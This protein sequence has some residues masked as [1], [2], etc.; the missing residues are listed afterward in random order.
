MASVPKKVSDTVLWDKHLAM[1]KDHLFLTFAT[2]TTHHL[3]KQHYG[4]IY[5]AQLWLPVWWTTTQPWTLN[6]VKALLL[7]I[8]FP[9]SS[10]KPRV[11]T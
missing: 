2:T 3:Y 9:S 11:D 4:W 8:N 7:P 1:R 6:K 10:Q 5:Q